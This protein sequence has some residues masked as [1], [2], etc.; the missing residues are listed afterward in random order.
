MKMHLL[1]IFQIFQNPGL[2]IKLHSAIM[3]NTVVV[4]DRF[5]D[6]CPRATGDI[7]GYGTA[8]SWEAQLRIS[9]TAHLLYYTNSET[10][11]GAKLHR[12]KTQMTGTN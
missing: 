6:I 1:K 4:S 8:G 10:A 12:N 9:I 5:P 2:T 11:C 3:D 7:H